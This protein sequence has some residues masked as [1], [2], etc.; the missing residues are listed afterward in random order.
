ME[1]AIQK[2][3]HVSITQLQIN[4]SRNVGWM[5]WLDFVE[6]IYSI[7]AK[8]SEGLKTGYLLRQGAG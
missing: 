1:E 7:L 4:V 3:E 2:I 5:N 6:K 8:S